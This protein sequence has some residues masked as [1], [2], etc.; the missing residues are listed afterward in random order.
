MA[1]SAIVLML[2][3]KVMGLQV[4][5]LCFFKKSAAWRHGLCMSVLV[6][7]ALIGSPLWAA[8]G[9]DQPGDAAVG[10]TV[11][12]D[13][14]TIFDD[15][16]YDGSQQAPA[17]AAGENSA[18]VMDEQTAL[19]I[20]QQLTRFE[21]N[22][23][24]L[25]SEAGPYD[26]SLIEALL[27]MGRYYTQIS[28]HQSAAG[29]F[30]R[31][32]NITRISD[33][34]LSPLQLPVLEELIE[35]HKAAGAWQLADDREHLAY[36][37]NT[38]LH[39]PGTQAY[40]DAA[41]ALGEWKMLALRGN[42]LGNSALGNIR[43]VESLR[44]IYRVALVSPVGSEMPEQDLSAQNLSEPAMS[45][46]T[47]FALLY[48]KALTEYNLAEYSLR[49][50][51]MQMQRPVERY[52]SEYVCTDVVGA[53]GQVSRS[54]ATVRRENPLYREMEM[55]RDFY[56]NRIKSAMVALE[57]SVD[58]MHALLATEPDLQ[59]PDGIPAQQRL[60]ELTTL[61]G[62]VNRAFRRSVILW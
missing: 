51:P 52:I 29:V 56:R 45:K 28:Q 43:E 41:V 44:E 35:A 50:L 8:D 27:D 60:D 58:E 17:S 39:A 13:G 2:G 23:A 19:E 61:Y 54:C 15:V 30:E 36:Y 21:E 48:G 10:A 14:A 22:L 26:V 59:A 5:E 49:T 57:D 9:V 53:N 40:A 62:T 24:T 20:S 38:R 7:M 42:L 33:G 6:T 4:L 46:Q 1:W 47:R 3:E 12:I 37:L 25:E 16:I 18:P 55:Q 31:A 34:L 32:L 11:V